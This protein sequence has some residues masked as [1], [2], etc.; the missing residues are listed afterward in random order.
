[1]R[2][3]SPYLREWVQWHLHAGIT[4]IYLYDN[5]V[6]LDEE[7]QKCIE[8][9]QEFIDAG[10]V[11]VKNWDEYE[12]HVKFLG[13][14]IPHPSGKPTKFVYNKQHLAM[15]DGLE[16]A[17]ND[18]M[19]LIFKFD[20]DEFL[21]PIDDAPLHGLIDR[22][23]N[24]FQSEGCAGLRMRS[25]FYGDSGHSSPP[26]TD[27]FGKGTYSVTRTYTERATEPHNF[28]DIGRVREVSSAGS[29]A[30]YWCY[31]LSDSDIVGLTILSVICA[32]ALGLMF[33]Y[34]VRTWVILIWA[35]VFIGA[36]VGIYVA[37]YDSHCD[38]V[39]QGVVRLNH[40][41][42]KTKEEFLSRRDRNAAL[43]Q[44]QSQEQVL[45]K[46]DIRNRGLDE[47]HDEKACRYAEEVFGAV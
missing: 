30:H 19:D 22:I 28:K 16:R 10:T 34:R 20:I 40:Y 35:I 15:Q 41:Y 6:G 17:R 18:G 44:Q 47:L 23:D 38:A 36:L 8:V 46:F 7:R 27:E 21:T 31:G 12:N 24:V 13:V 4:H 39:D 14:R 42:T 2:K 45:M 26:V 43:C 25:Y 32:V 3:E 29:S 33:H 37:M 1:M 11:S 5:N 9:L